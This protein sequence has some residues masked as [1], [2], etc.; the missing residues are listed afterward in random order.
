MYLTWFTEL[1]RL[2]PKIAVLFGSLIAVFLL[3]ALAIKLVRVYRLLKVRY[4][5]LEITPPAR[6]DRSPIA[7]TQLFTAIHGLGI[8]SNAFEK[9]F[10]APCIF[11]LE[12]ESTK[13]GGI[14][15]LVRSPQDKLSSLERLLHAYMPEVKIVK[16]KGLSVRNAPFRKI[17]SYRQKKHYAFPL[18][19]MEDLDAHDPIGYLTSAIANPSDDEHLVYQLLIKPVVNREA[20]VIANKILDNEDL[21]NSL[22]YRR[23]N[24][25][26]IFNVI[27]K[28]LFGLLDAVGSIYSH[29]SQHDYL[30]SKRDIEY[31]KQVAKHLKPVRTLSYFEHERVESIHQKLSEPLFN[32]EIRVSITGNDRKV[33]RD[34]L[35]NIKGAVTLFNVPKYQQLVQNKVSDKTMP[36]W[37]HYRFGRR[38]PSFNRQAIFSSLELAGLYHFPNK[39]SGK[40][41]NVVTSLSKTLPAPVALKSNQKLG[42]IIGQ[43]L[44]HGVTTPIGL[45]D[46][47]RERHVYTIGGT[48][49]GKTTML[50]YSIVQDIQN[51]NGVAILDPHGDLA[52]N[53]LGYIPPERIKDVIYLNPDDL[54][55][56]IGIN[57]LELAPN[58]EGDELLRE[59]DLITESA[60]S[61]LRKIFS[62]D[63]SGGHRIEYILRNTIQTALTLEN[64]TLFTIFRLLNDTKYRQGVVRNLED[65]DLKIFWKN[66]IAKAGE[67]QKVKMSA[68]IT[69]KVGRFLFSASAKRIL[70]QEKSSINFEEI[71]DGKKILV[72][73]F[74]KGLIGEDT[75][76]LFGTTVLAKLQVAALKRARQKQLERQ[77]F[78]LYVD[79]FQNF[80][81]MSF[82]QML[83]E[84]RKYKLFLTMAEQSTQQQQ[85]Q[86]LV[87]IILANV[88]TVVCFRSGSPADERLVLPLFAPYIEQGEIANLPAYTFYMR[89]AAVEAR[90]PLSGQ[91]LLLEQRPDEVTAKQVIKESRLK[92][93]KKIVVEQKPKQ[94]V[95]KSVKQDPKAESK[96]P[97]KPTVADQFAPTT[98]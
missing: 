17:V 49:N 76:T 10:N 53:I 19:T 59:K 51:G 43:N 7:T 64:P 66:E 46:A 82:V 31:K 65:N 54:T 48:G 14:R 26:G 12:I 24:T 38:L 45:T 27:N 50:L 88:G 75:S 79:E 36:R 71:L 1:A 21:L 69:S 28:V 78:Y 30:M 16:T 93:G 18:K 39:K 61:V 91:T 47:E 73:N 92:Y 90:E 58:L 29:E 42:V 6:G 23:V 70:E 85:Q 4:G 20:E 41:D 3:F 40:T 63:D 35:K 25:R 55:H 22:Q 52:E 60:I 94:E 32:T 33:I 89:I 95:P 86:R 87:D 84:A 96:A 62:E 77:P 15:Y 72:C 67:M 9:L 11:T 81:T 83:S 5:Y 74:S 34:R 56:P 80:A 57:L 2:L 13:S 8:A 97:A 44:H 68:G 37:L 98:D